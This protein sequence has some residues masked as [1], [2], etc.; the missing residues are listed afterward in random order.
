MRPIY[1]IQ[2]N[3]KEIFDFLR[4]GD[5]K[6]EVPVEKKEN[7][8]QIDLDLPREVFV[9]EHTT[10]AAFKTRWLAAAEQENYIYLQGDMTGA[11]FCRMTY[12]SIIA[13]QLNNGRG[14]FLGCAA[15]HV[16]F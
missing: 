14:R 7:L 6:W 3:P 16:S 11:A 8:N 5:L 12:G 15:N 2:G 4:L 1:L 9:D 10:F 13:P